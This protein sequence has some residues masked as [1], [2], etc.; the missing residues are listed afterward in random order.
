MYREHTKS[1]DEYAAQ[2]ENMTS[3][4]EILSASLESLIEIRNIDNI[5]INFCKFDYS[6]ACY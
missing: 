6:K 4:I 5:K 3:N 1:E 2:R